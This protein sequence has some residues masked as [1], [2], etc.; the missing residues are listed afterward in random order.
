MHINRK[1]KDSGRI[2]IYFQEDDKNDGQIMKGI[3]K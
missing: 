2:R 3:S 1:K